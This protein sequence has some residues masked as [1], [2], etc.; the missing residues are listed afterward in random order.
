[1]AL[2]EHLAE[3]RR[4]FVISAIAILLGAAVGWYLYT[5]VIEVL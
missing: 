5:P 2:R 1:M 3:L 4:R